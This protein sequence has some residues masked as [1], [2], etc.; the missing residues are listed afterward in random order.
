M[1][2]NVTYTNDTNNNIIIGGYFE[3]GCEFLDLF[4]CS[5]T[6]MSTCGIFLGSEAYLFESARVYSKW[7][8]FKVLSAVMSLFSMLKFFGTRWESLSKSKE[9]WGIKSLWPA[10]GC[11]TSI[12][13]K[14][15]YMMMWIKKRVMA[16]QQFD[17]IRWRIIE[18]WTA[19]GK[20]RKKDIIYIFILIQNDA[21][22]CI[23]HSD[24]T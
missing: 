13:R 22:V 9:S 15:G 3:F 19:V 23:K 4:V 17:I 1:F 8:V 16:W 14:T 21:L 10:C 7:W 2:T 6:I 24:I 20:G 18:S 5:A 12:V 11:D